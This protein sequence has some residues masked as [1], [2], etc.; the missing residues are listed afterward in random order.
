MAYKKKKKETKIHGKALIIQKKWAKKICK[1][2][3]TWEIRSSNTKHRGRFYIAIKDEI[4]GHADLVASF[5]VST[6]ELK[7]NK[8]LHKIKRIKETI[9]YKKPHAWKLKNAKKFKKAIKFN[10]L[11]GQVIWCLLDD[12]NNKK[13]I[14]NIKKA[15]F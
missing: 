7:N 13:A 6:K 15:S 2:N 14:Q 9:K 5:P 11:K 3:K 1:G 4:I 12:K 10:R 8:H